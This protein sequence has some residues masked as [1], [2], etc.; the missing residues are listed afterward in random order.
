MATKPFVSS[1]PIASGATYTAGARIGD[2]TKITIPDVANGYTPGVTIEPESFNFYINE[3]L[4]W[5]GDWLALGSA[6]GAEDAHI[7]ETDPTGYTSIA[8][9][10]VGG[11]NSAFLAM[12]ISA[13]VNAPAYSLLVDNDEGGEAV[14]AT[15]DS[16]SPTL[17]AINAGSG[18]GIQVANTGTGGG[19]RLIAGGAAKG[20]YAEGGAGGGNAVEGVA[21]STG[22]G[23][24]FRALGSGI[25]VYAEASSSG[26]AGSFQHNGAGA[27]NRGIINLEPTSQ[28]TIPVVGDVWIKAGTVGFGRGAFSHYDAD[29]ASGGGGAGFQKHWTTAAGIG[30]VY[31]ASE[32]STTE[33]AG[34]LTTKLTVTLDAAGSPGNGQGEYVVNYSCEV[35]LGAG[36][37]L[38][39]R[40]FIE[41]HDDSGVINE[42]NIDFV[43]V[44]QPKTVTCMRQVTLAAAPIDLKIKFKSTTGTDDVKMKRARISAQ[45]AYE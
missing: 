26:L 44:G 14:R 41:F 32:G 10:E 6:L 29:G 2:P 36:A 24:Y 4:T 3:L 38:T 16:S 35:E 37:A 22:H 21:T 18:Y 5:Q 40:C 34:V 12:S 19:A 43:A 25:G 11:S 13:S 17:Q 7:V 23:G 42:A 9:M 1:P 33:G 27:V 39:T 30:Y 15:N 20:V 8:A 28:P 31:G 45:G